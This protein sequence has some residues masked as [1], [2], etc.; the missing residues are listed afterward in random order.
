MRDAGEHLQSLRID[1]IGDEKV[2]MVHAVH[3]QHAVVVLS[4][5]EGKLQPRQLHQVDAGA[6]EC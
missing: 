3:A 2:H 4:G 5:G 6:A 1:L